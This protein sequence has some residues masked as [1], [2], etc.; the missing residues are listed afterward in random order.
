M[1]WHVCMNQT[2]SWSRNRRRWHLYCCIVRLVFYASW[3]IIKTFLMVAWKVT[4]GMSSYCAFCLTPEPEYDCPQMAL[5]QSNL[6]HPFTGSTVQ[7]W[8]YDKAFMCHH[9]LPGTHLTHRELL[10][11]KGPW[12]Q[13]ISALQLYSPIVEWASEQL[14]TTLRS[15]NSVFG[16]EQSDEA[17]AALRSFLEGDFASSQNPLAHFQGNLNI[18]PAN[19]FVIIQTN[20]YAANALVRWWF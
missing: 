18:E 14:G 10:W 8:L 6:L 19:R 12:S 3:L 20:Q 15:D 5:A 17:V 16:A 4:H 11:V 7:P 1:S 13:G 9:W 2:K